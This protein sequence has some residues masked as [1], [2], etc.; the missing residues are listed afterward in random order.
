VKRWLCTAVVACN[1]SS[2]P[3]PPTC[4][5]AS[6]L[7]AWLA[8]LAAE[9][10]PNEMLDGLPLATLDA[11]PTPAPE[12]VRVTIA[13]C[14]SPYECPQGD[15]LITSSGKLYGGAE[16]LGETAALLG[17]DLKALHDR[18]DMRGDLRVGLLIDA[19]A[20]WRPIA[21]VIGAIGNAGVKHLSVGFLAGKTHALAPGP[22]SIDAPLAAFDAKEN[23][24]LE[25]DPGGTLERTLERTE[26]LP[27][28]TAVYKDCP[29]ASQLLS[30]VLSERLPTDHKTTAIAKMLPDTV[31]ACGCR[32]EINALERLVWRLFDRD[33][34]PPISWLVVE[35][36]QDGAKFEAA[37][38]ATWSTMHAA[39][40]AAA[41][42]PLA[43]Q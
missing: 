34:R 15:V 23:A 16:T 9:D 11:Y 19:R 41:R 35:L 29:Q 24:D 2:A 26:P 6:E 32:I 37:A 43:F 10:Q 28:V 7:R 36:A 14:S 33:R 21:A 38:T 40:V 12:A 8:N 20:P 1:S 3:T 17:D 42:K 25:R 13:A 18:P 22:S 4:T 5:D 39:F 27:F 31:V 30:D